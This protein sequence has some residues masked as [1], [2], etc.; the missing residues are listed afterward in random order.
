MIL[1]I[2]EAL[3]AAHGSYDLAPTLIGT[4]LETDVHVRMGQKGD[5]YRTSTAIVAMRGTKTILNLIGDILAVP[6]HPANDPHVHEHAEFTWLSHMGVVRGVRSVRD[7]VAV[8]IDARQWAGIGH[9]YGAGG[10]L[11]L[12]AE[13]AAW[14][15]PPAEL[16]L[17]APMR[18]FWEQLPEVLKSIPIYAWRCGNDDVPNLP[19]GKYV[20]L[21][22][23]AG[24]PDWPNIH[25]TEF[26]TPAPIWVERHYLVNFDALA[27]TAA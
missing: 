17:F 5:D 1:S 11:E 4:G 25:W 14:G 20:Q 6:E 22:M 16:H 13:Y 10:V 24:L 7:Q 9:S 2:A 23:S 21:N 15:N 8:Q 26:G 19:G 12:A 18:V 3:A 27:P